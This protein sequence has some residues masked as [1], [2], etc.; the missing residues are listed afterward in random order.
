[1]LAAIAP[2]STESAK[3]AF[4]R[5]NEVP[6]HLEVRLGAA[7][8]AEL[9]NQCCRH[10]GSSRLRLLG[11]QRIQHLLV[12]LAR[13][14]EGLR[15]TGLRGEFGVRDALTVGFLANHSEQERAATWHGFDSFK[16]LP[17]TSTKSRHLGWVEGAFSKGYRGQALSG[18]LLPRVPSNVRLH[19]GWFNES[20]PL[21]LDRL[22]SES[23][24]RDLPPPHFAF[25]HMDA[26]IF[27]STISVLDAV[28]ERCMHRV[29]TV[30]AFD[31][32]FGPS[33]QEAHEFRAL[34]MA[35]A[36]W[37]VRY[38]FVSYTLTPASLYARAAVRVENASTAHCERKRRH[39]PRATPT[40]HVG[41]G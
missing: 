8:G 4:L 22:I 10:L 41:S 6:G 35:A 32:L 30:L 26:D 18:E 3:G 13:V 11:G 1:M 19:P 20:V 27:E 25:L 28:F 29:G 40:G 31:E 12:A 38:T 14:P 7:D 36:R 2:G 39:K 9:I 16:G 34:K 24:Q 37:G 5:R 23:R 17:P 15:A 33:A 21:V